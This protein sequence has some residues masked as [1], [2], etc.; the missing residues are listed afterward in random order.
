[1]GFNLGF[2]GLTGSLST[3][4]KVSLTI[5]AHPKPQHLDIAFKL[6]KVLVTPSHDKDH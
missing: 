1:M 4:K 6:L 3:G 2:K 5:L